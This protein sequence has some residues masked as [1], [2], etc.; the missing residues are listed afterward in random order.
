M[1]ASRRSAPPPPPVNSPPLDLA[2]AKDYSDRPSEV[3]DELDE[4]RNRGIAKILNRRFVETTKKIAKEKAAA[5]AALADLQKRRAQKSEFRPSLGGELN[6]FDSLYVELQQKKAECRRKER[7]TLLLYQRY[8][9]KYG[10]TAK[11]AAVAPKVAVSTASN[12]TTSQE[13]PIAST[14]SSP[15]TTLESPPPPSPIPDSAAHPPSVDE[16]FD[17]N[18]ENVKHHDARIETEEKTGDAAILEDMDDS[19]PILE[20]DVKGD[21]VK[22]EPVAPAAIQEL[23]EGPQ[24]EKP[25][26]EGDSPSLMQR[27]PEISQVEQS[28][29]L[30]FSEEMAKA[31]VEDAPDAAE[32]ADPLTQADDLEQPESGT[33]EALK[34][35][36]LETIVESSESVAAVSV[37]MEP[38][39]NTENQPVEESVTTNVSMA[40]R[41]STSEISETSESRPTTEV[42]TEMPSATSATDEDDDTDERSIISGLTSINSATTRKVMEELENE[43]EEFIKTETENIR[44]MIEAE[45]EKSMLSNGGASASSLVGSESQES[46]RQAELL[47]KQMQ[48]VLHDFTKGGL[49][50]VEGAEVPGEQTRSSSKYPY[51]YDSSNPN[52]QWMVYWDDTHKREYY[53]DLKSKRTQW[54]A[55]SSS[56]SRSRPEQNILSH[57]DVI[58]EFND[59][60]MLPGGLSRKARYRRRVRR[61]RIR[62][63]AG[64]SLLL[65]IGAMFYMH[66]Q[67]NHGEK[68]LFEAVVAMSSDIQSQAGFL[69]DQIEYAIT[70]RRL[71][72]E[73]ER[74]QVEEEEEKARVAAEFR[75]LEEQRAKEE[76]ERRSVADRKRLERIAAELKAR[77]EAHQR[78]IEVRQKAAFKHLMRTV[79]EDAKRRAR[80]YRLLQEAER[81]A[82]EEREATRRPW[83]CNLPL[84][85]VV[86]RKCRQLASLNPIFN[87]THLVNSFIQ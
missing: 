28:P 12:T 7:E 45:E 67:L 48:Q 26:E 33:M 43:L 86:N 57:S 34:T 62:R 25:A 22:P 60:T 41:H 29:E 5:D 8:V 13:A 76:A 53:H 52:E 56:S 31:L 1:V 20:V 16:N 4:L 37:P 24:P 72:E 79:E 82:R 81:K 80:E 40:V 49:P 27:E 30:E 23:P 70:D 54:E 15:S 75:R 18:I 71:K 61:Q 46:T 35:E 36:N 17:P 87:E 55:P 63:F 50:T 83:G 42:L 84:S 9:H 11:S 65:V 85:Y 39:G 64:F 32:C 38:Q 58:P 74:R 6:P 73:A 51:K 59:S 14:F 10:G 69:K 77:E 78:E 19:T 21:D 66:W 44:K 47:A 3:Q 68:S 2:K